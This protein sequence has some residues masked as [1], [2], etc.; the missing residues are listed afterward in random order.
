MMSR[1]NNEILTRVGPG[2]PMGQALRRFWIP[3]LLE[4]EVG[5]PDGA[6]VRL[7]L[8][9]EDLIAFRDTEGRVGVVEPRCAHRGTDLFFGRN[10][11]CGLRCVF[12]GWKYDID[13][14]CVDMPS[15]PD[16]GARLRHQV[17]I[18]A[19]PARLRGGVVWVYMGPPEFA[20][21][22]P[23]FEFVTLPA[24]Q[25][26][27]IRRLQRCNWVQSVEGGLDSSHISFL[28]A[29]TD[30]QQASGD[31]RDVAPQFWGV[32]RQPVFEVRRTPYGLLVGARRETADGRYY[33]RITQCL[34][35]FY[36]LVPPRKPVGESAGEFYWGHAWVPIDDE[37]TW[38]WSFSAQ[39][40][41]DYTDEELAWN[42]GRDGFWGP[43]DESYAPLRN[44][45]NDYLI[46]RE[47][48]NK[49]SFSGIEGF[50][51]Q[52][53]AAQ[54]TMGAIADRSREFL[55][56]S[57]RAIVAYRRMML[58]LARDCAKGKEP[59]VARRGDWYRVRS[60]T[61]VL[62]RDQPFDKAA[63]TLLKAGNQA[64]AD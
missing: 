24:R 14:N 18:T 40:W 26:T 3:A 7:R 64:A 47:R 21:E 54:E 37:T 15:E 4:E 19:Y 39:P 10:E 20:A 52:D 16:G 60:A 43:L 12:H 62:D 29:R 41:R 49:V 27:A 33:W 34:L 30:A 55:G 36:S 23:D 1:E 57:D 38:A 50:G 31:P 51:D 11:E 6:L 22:P 48:Q 63:A 2:T 59:E 44:R 35:P 17:T 32:D 46:D 8:L 42:G 9:G 25:R 28:H 58:D 56:Q 13:G 5:E 61:V 53:A 45:D